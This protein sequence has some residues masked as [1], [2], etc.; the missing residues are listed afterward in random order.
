MSAIGTQESDLI[1]SRLT[2]WRST[3]KKVD[4]VVPE[5]RRKK[6]SPWVSIRVSLVVDNEQVDA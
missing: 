5:S 2:R 3:V 6:K 4:T 1:K